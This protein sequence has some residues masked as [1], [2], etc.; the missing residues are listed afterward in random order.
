MEIVTGRSWLR[1]IEKLSLNLEY[2]GEL[3]VYF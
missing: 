1:N 2:I 3:A